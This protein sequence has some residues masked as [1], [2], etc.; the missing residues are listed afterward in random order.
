MTLIELLAAIAIMAF[1]FVILM[2]AFAT[3]IRS[4]DKLED[5]L[6]TL[7]AATGVMDLLTHDLEQIHVYDSRAYFMLSQQDITGQKI[8]SIAFP[9]LSPMRVSDDLRQNPGL[10]E[11]AY[12]AA[13]DPKNPNL[14]QVQRRELAIETNMAATTIRN[15]DQGLVLLADNLTQFTID[16][17]PPPLPVTNG[18]PSTV[19]DFTDQWT[20]GFG[21]DKIPV[22]VR[23]QLT[24]GGTNGGPSFSLERTIRMPISSVQTEMLESTMTSALAAVGIT[25][26][27][28]GSTAGS[29]L[30]VGNGGG[31][32][33]TGGGSGGS[34][35]GRSGVGGGVGGAGGAGGTGGAG[36]G[37]GGAGGGRGGRSGGGSGGTG[38]G[39]PFGGAGGSPFGRGG[40]TG[41]K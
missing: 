20:G 9:C 5:R 10:I 1:M 37:R 6:S 34:G 14:I 7:E 24:G 12:L 33:A 23:I 11:V 22:A 25:S 4:R 21:A 13:Q 32:G 3:T 26:S 41:G 18:S 30:T 8:T 27:L 39:S 17:L 40:G 28:S 31:G 16:F 36:G 38:G 29:S 2:S 15:S 19:T 35:G